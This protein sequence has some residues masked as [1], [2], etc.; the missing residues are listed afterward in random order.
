MGVL[1]MVMNVAKARLL[2][3]LLRRGIGGNLATVMLVAWAGKKAVE[4]A[5]KKRARIA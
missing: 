3:R 5:R 4:M 1:N 2:A